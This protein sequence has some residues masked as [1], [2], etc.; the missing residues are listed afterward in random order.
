MKMLSDM[1]TAQA[2]F[3][4]DERYRAVFGYGIPRTM[5]PADGDAALALINRAI[6]TKDD[7][8]FEEGLPEGALI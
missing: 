1:L 8:I 3:E 7:S 4:L 6:D 5:L 2:S